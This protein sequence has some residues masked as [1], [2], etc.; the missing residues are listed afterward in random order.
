MKFPH[1]NT[2]TLLLRKPAVAIT[3]LG[4]LLFSTSIA[5]AAPI[6]DTSFGITGAFTV[7]TGSSLGTT[8]SIF[9]A[10]GGLITVSAPDSLDL[11]G[12]VNFGD[13]GTLQDLPSISGFTPITN[14]ISLSDGVSVDLN[15]LHLWTQTGPVPGFINMYGDATIHAIGFDATDG[16]LTFTGTSS[17]NE[18][19]TLGVTTSASSPNDTPVPEPMTFALLGLGLAGLGGMSRFKTRSNAEPA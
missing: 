7:P 5:V 2:I 16:T 4:G 3:V 19:F 13:T 6:T 11:A 18:S 9:I 12:I 10:N 14:Y 17:D 15:T 1:S 8:D